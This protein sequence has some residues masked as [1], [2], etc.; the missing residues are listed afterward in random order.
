MA[1]GSLTLAC[2]VMQL[3]FSESERQRY[4]RIVVRS[5][6][7]VATDRSASDGVTL[8]HVRVKNDVDRAHDF[9]FGGYVH[10]VSG[11]RVACVVCVKPKSFASEWKHVYEHGWLLVGFYWRGKSHIYAERRFSLLGRV[12]FGGG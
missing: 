8:V 11:C 12:R 9:F 1:Q 2:P 5:G 10:Y 3:T 7:L 6:K 4:L